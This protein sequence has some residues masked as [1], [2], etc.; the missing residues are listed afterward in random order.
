MVELNNCD[1]TDFLEDRESFRDLPK[2]KH[3]QIEDLNERWLTLSKWAK[4]RRTFLTSVIANLQVFRDYKKTA[5]DLIETKEKEVQ[6][7]NPQVNL[8]KTEDSKEDVEK[9]EVNLEEP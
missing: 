3:D 5:L 2:E 8:E 1:V 9:L 4:E 6:E 7:M